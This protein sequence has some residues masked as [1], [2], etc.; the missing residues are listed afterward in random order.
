MKPDYKNWIPI[1]LLAL[2]LFFS[3]LSI[4]LLLLDLVLLSG[5]LRIVLAVVLSLIALFS[6]LMLAWSCYGYRTF[7]YNGRRQLSREI[8]EG[9]ARYIELPEGGTCLDVGCGSGALAIAVA[10]RN[11]QGMV[12]GIDKWGLEYSSFSKRLCENNAEA[13]G[14]SNISFQRQDAVSLAFDDESFDAIVSNYVYHNIPS[15]NRQDILMESLRCLRKGGSF[16]L[17]DIFSREKYGNMDEFL[18]KLRALGFEKV[19]LIGTVGVLMT[20]KEARLI[21]LEGSALLVGRK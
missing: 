11:P 8:I 15:K 18:S 4:A 17:H 5:T 21:G 7:S 6:L 10:R 2:V 14:V 20:K 9:V 12:T 19:E 13:E 1:E 16:A 3:V